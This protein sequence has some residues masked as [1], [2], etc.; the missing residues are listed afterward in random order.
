MGIASKLKNSAKRNKAKYCLESIRKQQQ[1]DCSQIS[2]NRSDF[3]IGDNHLIALQDKQLQ[4]SVKQLR[5]NQ[6]IMLEEPIVI[7]EDEDD[8][9]FPLI[10]ET[11]DA[12]EGS[13]LCMHPVHKHSFQQVNFLLMGGNCSG[14]K[15]RLR[16]VFGWGSPDDQIVRCIA[17]GAYAHRACAFSSKIVDELNWEPCCV[18]AQKIRRSSS[19]SIV[20]AS[21]VWNTEEIQQQNNPQDDAIQIP[22]SPASKPIYIEPSDNSGNV[23]DSIFSDLEK[24]MMNDVTV[25]S[26]YEEPQ[27]SPSFFDRFILRRGQHPPE[28]LTENAGTPTEK[29]ENKLKF[30]SSMVWT[31]DGPPQHW[32]E[33]SVIHNT[34]PVTGKKSEVV[35]KDK[36]LLSIPNI[37]SD[38]FVVASHDDDDEMKE[39][40]NNSPID[41]KTF[42]NVARA[43]QE[44]VLYHFRLQKTNSSIS[45]L[46]TSNHSDSNDVEGCFEADFEDVKA[47]SEE[48]SSNDEFCPLLPQNAN[49][50]E[51]S[52]AVSVSESIDA[53]ILCVELTPEQKKPTNVVKMASDTYQ[54]VKKSSTVGKRLEIASITG[55]VIGGVAGLFVAGPAGM[56]VGSKLFQT[57]GVLGVIVD[58][59]MAV[60]VLIAGATAGTL[61][62]RQLEE[63]HQQRI[64]EIGE[65][66]VKQKL[67]LVRPQI[68]IDPK[69]TE[70]CAKAKR[71]APVFQRSNGFLAVLSTS[72]GKKQQHID[73]TTINTFE[74]DKD[75]VQ[76]DEFELPTVDKVLLLVSRIL[77]DKA[78]LP[79][80]VY[81]E[82]INVYRKRDMERLESSAEDFDLVNDAISDNDRRHRRQ[83]VHAVIK[84]VTA[85]L[86]EVRPG[87]GSS[88]A[89]T[90]MAATAVESL[91]FGKLYKSVLE[92][93][94]DETRTVDQALIEKIM[95]FDKDH[96][97]G[98][99][100]DEIS[101]LALS[102]LAEV[103]QAETPVDKLRYFVAFLEHVSTHFS[104]SSKK[105]KAI[106]ADSLLKMVCQHLL[107]AKVPYL[108]AEITFLEEFARDERLLQGKE[109]YALVT[110][111]ASL[112]FLNASS[113]F[114][115]DIFLASDD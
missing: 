40:N 38:D 109:G 54:V 28:I 32:A 10:E 94:L 89:I 108:N 44:N 36:Q 16:S 101:D 80:H 9:P 67:V 31:D 104:E 50:E 17:C 23:G 106:G 72:P 7:A 5:I 3:A 39:I 6:T 100:W 15:Q 77:N 85:T 65:E 102:T 75:I 8:G 99:N 37:E 90:E 96:P 42:G 98:P 58:S 64:L 103:P 110:L 95:D 113:D 34:S 68:C 107:V 45:G 69:W 25:P 84:H 11:I 60:G 20:D 57:V 56:V 93:I 13:Q 66:A 26:S 115:K 19:G 74:R 70:I 43:L 53:E 52:D 2:L 61:T 22:T 12:M 63:Q 27:N 86:L 47:V 81:R 51:P 46:E 112:H 55:G 83:D 1:Q 35:V 91:V 18:N 78:S 30:D 82:L 24:E 21:T 76:T 62:A 105:N 114:D 14:C 111:Q 73:R 59:T 71:D 79:G 88:P 48:R 92:E 41:V 29:E 33:E 4:E 87:F 49:Q 97:N